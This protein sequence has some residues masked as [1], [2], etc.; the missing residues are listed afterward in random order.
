MLKWIRWPGFI[1]FI[2]IVAGLLAFFLLLAGPLTKSMIESLGTM[3]NGAKVEVSKV[4][5]SF[6][7][8][9]LS[10]HNLQVTDAREPM[11]NAL[12]VKKVVVELELAPLFAGRGIIRELT[13]DGLEF[14]TAR[15]TSGEVKK[16]AKQK[17]AEKEESV[18]KEALDSIEL[19]S[20][21][22][23]IAKE[24]LQT[25]QAGEALKDS[26]EN[27]K[28]ELEQRLAAVP[29]EDSLKAYESELKAIVQGDIKSLDDF[30]ARKNKLD[31]LKQKMKAD[32]VAVEAARNA[33]SNTK[34]VMTDGI[35]ALK[36]APAKDIAA[37]REKYSLDATGATNVTAML[38]GEEAA[39][40]ASQ[41]LYWYEKIKPY[42]AS[43]DNT[44]TATEKPV[45]VTKEQPPVREGR[46]VHFPTADPWP[47]FL[48]R[49]IRGSATLDWGELR[50]SGR[51]LTHQPKVLNRPAVLAAQGDQLANMDLF[52]LDLTLDHRQNK[53]TDKLELKID[54]WRPAAMS[55]G[56]A[57][58][59]LSSA[60]TQVRSTAVVTGG[61]LDA[62]GVA[63]F[64]DVKFTGA[65]KSTFEKELS[66]ALANVQQ[67][68]VNATAQGKL[69]TPK[70]KLSSDLD[71]QLSQAF[72]QR[73]HEKQKEFEK[74]LKA[75]LNAKLESYLG[76]NNSILD[77]LKQTE[78][79]L[80]A[81][82]DTLKTLGKNE[83]ADFEEQQKQKA[84]EKL[85]AKKEEAK[86]KAKEDVKSKLKK[87]F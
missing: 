58:A 69:A 10:V 36:D 66:L 72:N 59:K 37:I 5:L 74:Q 48:I 82:L 2:A 27:S 79:G 54:N 1:A 29:N 83:L 85:D 42:L 6:N 76:D 14:G 20:A 38:F 26:Y 13:V 64:T 70:V 12:Q 51:D 62:E 65:Q 7:P 3:A 17:P 24:E 81:K 49:N 75:E 22:E 35:K 73:I 47:D 25:E 57:D 18:I 86:E 23:I 41:A 45:E 44:Q 11:T 87:L 80:S 67:F 77:E 78:G 15:K 55:L 68:E 16:K 56:M 52:Q 60:K 50:L 61:Q 8:L 63:H 19:P 33:L 46:L 21:K 43:D 40:W 71:K 28:N 30:K 34:T 32:Q 84:K 39:E 53:N 31:A 4:N 9:G